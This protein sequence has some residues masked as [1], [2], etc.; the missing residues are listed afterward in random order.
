MQKSALAVQSDAHRQAAL[1]LAT[2]AGC[3]SALGERGRDSTPPYPRHEL[4][5]VGSPLGDLSMLVK[6][7]EKD[8]FEGDRRQELPTVHLDFVYAAITL[9]G[10]PS[11][12]I[13]LSACDPLPLLPE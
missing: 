13:R 11:Q 3:D 9:F 8:G 4:Y 7:P 2:P 6:D 1:T 10:W 5:G 12:A